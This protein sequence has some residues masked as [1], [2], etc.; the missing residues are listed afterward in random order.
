MS[1]PLQHLPL[2]VC[3]LHLLHLIHL[4]LLEHL[5]CVEALI[6]LALYEMHTSERASAERSLYLEVLQ[7]VFAL[8]LALWV[9]DWLRSWRVDRG[10]VVVAIVSSRGWCESGVVL[11]DRVVPLVL[12][13]LLLLLVVHEVLDRGL[14]L[15]THALLRLRLRLAGRGGDGGLLRRVGGMRLGEE[16]AVLG[17]GWRD[18][19]AAFV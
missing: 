12:R 2:V 16:V 19:R 15:C 4:R 14:N 5:D 8:G 9:G 13:L 3:V 1:T 18:R 11:R 7:R 6:V 17:E 10:D